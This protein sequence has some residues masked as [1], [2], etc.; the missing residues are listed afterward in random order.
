[1]RRNIFKVV[2]GNWQAWARDGHIYSTQEHVAYLEMDIDSIYVGSWDHDPS[3]EEIAEA[4]RIA[5]VTG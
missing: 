3:T 2:P 1:M 5:G 4:S